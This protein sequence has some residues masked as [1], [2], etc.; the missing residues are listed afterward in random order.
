M[1]Y[2][3]P[4]EPAPGNGDHTDG[5]L[6]LRFGGA[7]AAA[8]AAG[9]ARLLRTLWPSVPVPRVR[10]VVADEVR[11]DP[12]EGRNGAVLCDG[13]TAAAVLA[14]CGRTLAA[15]HR[16][17]AEVALGGPARVGGVLVH[18]DFGPH[19]IWFASDSLTVTGVVGWGF[20]H[21]GRPL[22]DLAWCEWRVRTRHPDC[23]DA[24][25]HLYHG[26]GGAMPP[27]AARRAAM[28][29]KCRWMWEKASR[30]RDGTAA[31]WRRREAITAAWRS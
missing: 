5:E 9:H 25:P 11:C 3:A 14:A 13:D 8:D 22:E 21:L 30:R 15:V 27:W 23:L 4:G 12:V 16:V 1:D 19:R 7:D 6:R 31:T 29:A 10:A 24:L 28:V 2:T 17:D 20:A 26:Y 18:G